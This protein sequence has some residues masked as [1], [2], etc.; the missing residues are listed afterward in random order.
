M[1]STP[2]TD[3]PADAGAARSLADDLRRRSDDELAQLLTVR[4]DL[5]RPLPADLTALAA[6]A[7]T[8]AS[9]QRAVEALDAGAL[10]ALQGLVVAGEPVDERWAGE[11]LGLDRDRCATA[12]AALW[13]R[14]LVWRGQDGLYLPRA[15]VDA[16]GPVVAGLAPGECSPEEVSRTARLLGTVDEAD[17]ALLDRLAWGPPVGSVAAGGPR[18]ERLT[19]LVEAGL[20]RPYGPDEY[21]LPRAVALALRDGR[22]HRQVLLEPPPLPG[23]PAGRPAG[24]EA[25][26]DPVDAIGGASA[27]VLL[28]RIDELAELWGPAPPRVLRAGGLSVADLRATARALD[29]PG[30]EAAFLI[31]LS[32]AAGLVDDDAEAEPVWAPTALYDDWAQEP[33]QRRWITLAQ[34]WLDTT[35]APSLVGRRPGQDGKGPAINAL[36]ETAHTALGRSVRRDVLSLLAQFPAGLAAERTDLARRLAWSRPLRQPEVLA[37]LVQATLREGAWL[38]ITGYDALTTAGRLLFG[39]SGDPA[40]LESTVA[41]S[42]PAPID[43]ILL[44]ADLTAVAPGHLDGDLARFL[45]LAAD[46]ESR[47]GATVYRFTPE[48][49]RR[50]LDMG[51]DEQ[52][53]LDALRRASRHDVPQPLEYLVRDVSR[54]HGQLRVGSATAYLRCDDPASIDELALRKDLSAYRIRRIGPGAAIAQV[55]PAVLLGALRDAGLSPVAEDPDGTALPTP[56]LRHRASGKRH[57]RQPRTV[58]ESMTPALAV[59]HVAALRSGDQ[60][61]R[62]EGTDA[63]APGRMQALEPAETV[64][65]LRD[66]ASA[67]RSVWVSTVDD[68]G[69]AHRLRLTPSGVAGG[70][71]YGHTDEGQTC[72]LALHRVAAVGSAGVPIIGSAGGPAVGSADSPAS[73]PDLSPGP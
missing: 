28:S 19:R 3:R 52:Q 70:R 72:S 5:A 42:L 36:S 57:A 22:L 55:S 69:M 50:P 18:S 17:R 54:R 46:V 58:V 32:Y 43:H 7:T 14:A 39:G 12:V 30:D 38:G 63:A 66:A 51:W 23:I 48:S 53:L 9:V 21:L 33:P 40:V 4:P 27:A 71:V 34:A 60:A 11:L 25:A 44:Q 47:G 26:P 16:L 35:R 24:Q 29:I 13:R 6:R 62:L 41:A 10:A 59:I 56:D 61:S 15:V 49:L 68:A 8:T 45:R 20:L 65:Y 1:T 73:D 37:E 31:E 2:R 64:A 67:G